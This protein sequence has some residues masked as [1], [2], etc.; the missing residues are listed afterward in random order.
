MPPAERPLFVRPSLSHQRGGFYSGKD[1]EWQD[2]AVAFM[3]EKGIGLFY[4]VLQPT[5]A[6]GGRV[7]SGRKCSFSSVT[8]SQIRSCSQGPRRFAP[9]SV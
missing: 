7:Q 1:K 4:F 3:A 8:I 5:C 9:S 2:W 6:S